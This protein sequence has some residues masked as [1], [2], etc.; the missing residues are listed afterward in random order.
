MANF[1]VYFCSS[2]FYKTRESMRRPCPVLALLCH[3]SDMKSQAN[4]MANW[5]SDPIRLYWIH[6]GF[7]YASY[8]AWT[9]TNKRQCHSRVM[10]ACIGELKMFGMKWNYS[11]SW[12]VIHYKMEICKEL[13]KPI[14]KKMSIFVL[15]S[16]S[17]HEQVSDVSC[18]YPSLMFDTEKILNNT[19]K[20]SKNLK[21]E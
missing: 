20:M 14:H 17:L 11:D 4:G 6:I 2:E 16:I 5:K 12:I 10:L 15:W 19:L 8:D 21:N 3:N 9:S 7:N 13:M 18:W 1:V